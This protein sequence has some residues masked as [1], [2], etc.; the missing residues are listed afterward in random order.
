MVFETGVRICHHMPKDHEADYCV[1]VVKSGDSAVSS[2][3]FSTL[4]RKVVLGITHNT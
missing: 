4:P 3:M 1:Q 2:D